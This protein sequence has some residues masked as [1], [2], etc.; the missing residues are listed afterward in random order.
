ML[1]NAGLN[2]ANNIIFI[3]IDGMDNQF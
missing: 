3:D 2:F 1:F